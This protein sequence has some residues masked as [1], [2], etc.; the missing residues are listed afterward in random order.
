MN[1][2]RISF[3]DSDYNFLEKKAL[4]KKISVQDYIREVVLETKY[5]IFTPEEA[6]KRAKQKI[7]KGG[8]FYLS[9]LYETE[10]WTS[11]SR[12]EAGVFGKRFFKYVQGTDIEFIGMVCRKAKYKIN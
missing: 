3:S 1:V 2:L 12:G 11:I 8:T 5:S 9:D 6:V 4:E 10:E 7:E